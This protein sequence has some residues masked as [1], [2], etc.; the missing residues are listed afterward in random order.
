LKSN[1][2]AGF[3]Y[4]VGAGP[5]DPGLITINGLRAIRSAD[6]ILHDR[7]VPAELV[8]RARRHALVIDVGKRAGFEDDQQAAI[9]AFMIEYAKRGMTVCRLKGGDPFIFGRGGEEIRVLLRSGI[10]FEIVPGV[11]SAFAAP[12]TAG[13]PLTHRCY[14]RAFMVIAGSKSSDLA[15]PEWVAAVTLLKAGGAVVVMMGLARLGTLTAAL[16]TAGCSPGTPVALI[17][18]AT[19]SDQRVV[20]GELDGI[21]AVRPPLEPPAILVAGPVVEIGRELEELLSS[22][23]AVHA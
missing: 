15:A 8:R 2:G 13:I 23:G 16:L 14:N 19:W 10:P 1:E 4:I 12:A 7:L 18:K 22:M 21:S 9:H 5:G 6:V 20:F 17:S 3:V 11:S